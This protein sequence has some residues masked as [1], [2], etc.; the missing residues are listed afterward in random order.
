MTKS[1][2]G[3]MDR[4]GRSTKIPTETQR[5]R[6]G[7]SRRRGGVRIREASSSSASK[8]REL[9]MKGEEAA[10][11]FLMHRGYDILER[12]W[13]CPAGEVDIIAKDDDAL[14]FV[15]VKTRSDMS[16]GFPSEAVTKAK[17]ERYEKIALAYIAE[18][19]TVHLCVRFDTVS[20]VVVGEGRAMVR[21]HINAFSAD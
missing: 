9:G 2:A 4:P 7:T 13:S 21:H 20:L 5:T 12:N 17:R 10:A 1:A 6:K 19:S 14:I 11:R 8:N 16:R 18:H 3:V 15:E